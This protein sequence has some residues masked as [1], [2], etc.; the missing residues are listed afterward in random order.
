MKF[1]AIFRLALFAFIS[2]LAPLIQF[3][4][5]CFAK[6]RGIFFV[7][8][9][10]HRAVCRIFN[11]KVH[12]T[13]ALENE[14]HTLYLTNHVSYLDIPVLGGYLSASFIAKA[15]VENW[16]LFGFL[17]KLQ[18]TVFIQRTRKG[19]SSAQ[20]MI[21]D[22][23]DQGHNLTLFAEGTSTQGHH[24]LPFKSSL[25][26]LIATQKIRDQLYIQPITIQVKAINGAP[27]QKPDDLDIYA[28]HGDMTLAPHLWQL[29]QN[30]SVDINLHFHPAR[31]VKEFKDRKD[32]AKQTH[33]VVAGHLQFSFD[34]QQ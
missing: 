32:I 15:D 1:I 28:W 10:W 27:P 16:P 3:P 2:A 33:K 24:V 22:R 30:K 12:V 21:E 23:L 20:K 26:E 14:H 31:P 17:S 7:P 13:G 11:I 18:K 8:K 25:F 4:I 5:L 9:I 29:A 6:G 19:L 34:P